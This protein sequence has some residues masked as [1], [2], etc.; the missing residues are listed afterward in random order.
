[1]LYISSTFYFTLE[2]RNFHH[3]LLLLYIYY[4]NESFRCAPLSSVLRSLRLCDLN[5]DVAKILQIKNAGN[6]VLTVH[7]GQD[8]QLLTNI[9]SISLVSGSTSKM[10]SSRAEI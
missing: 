5:V 2:N 1:M 8:E 9:F 4:N 6:T 7:C 3:I 10:S